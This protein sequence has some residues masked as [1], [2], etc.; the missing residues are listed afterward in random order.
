[1][2]ARLFMSSAAL[3]APEGFLFMAINSTKM[4][5]FMDRVRQLVQ[6]RNHPLGGEK[7][8]CIDP[9]EGEESF[10]LGLAPGTDPELLFMTP[11]P[12]NPKP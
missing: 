8:P 9:L 2:N 7:R 1:V 10:Y 5:A 3:A 6:Q 4:D 12:L 11:P